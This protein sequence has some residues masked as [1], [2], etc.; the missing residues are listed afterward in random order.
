MVNTAA[1]DEI[2]LLLERFSHRDLVS[3]GDVIDLLLDVRTI[4]MVEEK[5]DPTA[6]PVGA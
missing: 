2:D 6:E 5:T 4:L 1:I 3:A